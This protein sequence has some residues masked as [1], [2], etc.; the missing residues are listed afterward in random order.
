MIPKLICFLFGHRWGNWSSEV[1]KRRP[2]TFAERVAFKPEW[3]SLL[4]SGG[5][6]WSRDC[7]RC[8]KHQSVPQSW[9]T[10]YEAP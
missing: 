6:A 1:V 10:E 7:Q 9:E 2:V 5:K 3:L 4:E 8:C